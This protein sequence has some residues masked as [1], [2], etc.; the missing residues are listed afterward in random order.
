MV[1]LIDTRRLVALDPA[2]GLRRLISLFEKGVPVGHAAQKPPE[3]DEVK[4]VGGE[5]PLAGVILNFAAKWF[6]GCIISLP[7]GC[8]CGDLQFQV[9]WDPAR[10]DRGDVG[11][12]YFRLRKFVRK[13]AR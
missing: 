10:L 5:C 8:Y 1:T 11:P 9:R 13:I 12:G 3:M 6:S 7:S 2:S 4:G